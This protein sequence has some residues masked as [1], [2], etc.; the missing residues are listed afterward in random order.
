MKLL[1]LTLKEFQDIELVSFASILTASNKFSK[2]DYYS[3]DNQD[4]VVGQFNV[5]HIKT[6]KSFNV[7]D[8]DA[9]YVPGGVGAIHLRSNQKGLECVKEFVQNNKLVIAICDAP[10]AL[11]ENNILNKDDKYISWSDGTMNGANRIKDFN[12]QLNCSNKLITARCSLTTLELAFYTLEV[13]FS[14]EFSD[15]LRA[16]LT[17]VA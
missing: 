1:V 2:I 7:N 11:S 8:Y 4:S 5:A 9:I 3:P 6:I 12:T 13:L 16:K 14:K 17:G 10:N 15:E